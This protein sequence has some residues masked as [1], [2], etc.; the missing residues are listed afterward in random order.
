MEDTA[1]Q[2][3]PELVGPE[4]FSQRFIAKIFSPEYRSV[5]KDTLTPVTDW[6]AGPSNRKSFTALALN[7]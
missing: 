1:Q 3:A 2:S 7:P 5:S 6:R 4:F